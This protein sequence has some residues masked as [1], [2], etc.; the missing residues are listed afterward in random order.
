MVSAKTVKPTQNE[1]RR[2]NIERTTDRQGSGARVDRP[3]YTS[4]T[5][6]IVPGRKKKQS[7]TWLTFVLV[8]YLSTLLSNPINIVYSIFLVSVIMTK[9]LN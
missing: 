3:K 7:R 9:M 5:K 2:I 1:N 6:F 8:R 4:G